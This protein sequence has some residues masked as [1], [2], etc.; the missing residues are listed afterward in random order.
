MSTKVEEE[1]KEASEQPTEVSQEA[2]EL[3]PEE[4]PTTKQFQEKYY[5]LLETSINKYDPYTM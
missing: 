1:K 3:A 2:E 4:D 5:P